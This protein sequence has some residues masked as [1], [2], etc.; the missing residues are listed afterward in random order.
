MSDI[1][2]IIIIVLTNLTF[3][4]K[5]KKLHC[6]VKKGKDGIYYVHEVNNTK[7]T[8]PTGVPTQIIIPDKK[9]HSRKKDKNK[10]QY[11]TW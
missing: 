2:I 7:S 3:C 6:H 8:T 9:S 1:K 4:S 5:K 11:H 10:V